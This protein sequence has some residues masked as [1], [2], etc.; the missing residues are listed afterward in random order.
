MAYEQ[1]GRSLSGRL[2]Q[3][4]KLSSITALNEEAV[5]IMAVGQRYGA[6]VY[7]L[8]GEP[9]DKRLSRL[10]TTAGGCPFFR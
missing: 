3:R 6:H 10:L 2:Q 7:A 9:A 8:L 1:R 5:R 4:L